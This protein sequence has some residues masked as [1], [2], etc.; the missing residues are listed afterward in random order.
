MKWWH[1]GELVDAADLVCSIN[2]YS[3]HYGFVVFEGIRGYETL[4]GPMLFRLEE[5]IARFY[6]SARALNFNIQGWAQQEFTEAV[7]LTAATWGNQDLYIRPMLYLGNGVMGIRTASPEQHLAVLIWPH[8]T[9]QTDPKYVEGIRVQVSRHVRP[10]AYAQAKIS[11]NYLASIAAVNSL[12]GTTFDEAILLDESGY[13]CEASAHNL[14]LVKDGELH[15]PRLT[16]CL[17][18]I[19]RRT[20]IDIAQALG[21]SV[22]E[23]DLLPTELLIADEAFLTGTASE[24]I[25]IRQAESSNLL[26]LSAEAL[27]RCLAR[28]YRRLTAFH[29]QPLT[30]IAP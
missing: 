23:R 28:E 26:T 8:R 2:T 11:G 7:R 10:K 18:G 22:H 16:A 3:L 14:F 27:T 29:D 6:R 1:Q 30:E 13:L 20:V 19:T 24:I 21:V 15:T 17:D 12:V 25:P 4:R 5:H 9:D